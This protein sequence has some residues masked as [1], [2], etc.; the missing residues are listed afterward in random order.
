M[1]QQEDWLIQLNDKVRGSL[2]GGAAGD[3]L[4]FAVEF[5]D[6]EYIFK[7]MKLPE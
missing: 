7:N 4:G 5:N 3:A 2:I 1:K 6:E